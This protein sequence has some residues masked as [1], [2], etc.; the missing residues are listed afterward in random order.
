MRFSICSA[1][2]L[3]LLVVGCSPDPAASSPPPS[4]AW[5]PPAADILIFAPHSD[6]EAIGCTGVILDAL[7]RKQ[8]VAVVII[9]AGDAHA[10]IA[11]VIAGREVDQLVPEDFL[12]LADLRQQ[13]SQRAMARLGLAPEN[14]IFLG[15]PDGSLARIREMDGDTPLRQPFTHQR[16]TYGRIAPDYHSQ[17]H[18]HPAP[19]TRRAILSDMAE[20]IKAC[21]PREIYVTHAADTHPD[22]AASFGYV[23]E[24]AQ[25]AGYTGALFTYVVHGRAP[26]EPPDR[27][28]ALTSA[29]L[30]TKHEILEIYQEGASPVHDDLAKNYA[31]PEERFW[32]ADGG[33]T[34]GK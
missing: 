34:P 33:S 28:L 15:Y 24:A 13:H 12:K 18:G 11:A 6:D 7:E 16:E 8:R 22:H 29:R 5:Q 21:R 14:L 19:Y 27:A 17:V 3:F 23:R 10:R 32:Q 1:A 9:T 2:L 31:L 25:D 4:S 26:Q 30:A 20:I